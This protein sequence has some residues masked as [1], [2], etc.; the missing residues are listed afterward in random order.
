MESAYMNYYWIAVLISI[1]VICNIVLTI[2]RIL[3][4][5]ST[6]EVSGLI[7]TTG[8]AMA[9]SA[10]PCPKDIILAII[11]S[12]LDIH[13]NVGTDY[14]VMFCGLALIVLGIYYRRSI[15]DKIFVLNM[16]GIHT[17]IEISEESHLKE[18]HLPDFKVKENIID[19]VDLFQDGKMS[20]KKNDIIVKKINKKCNEFLNRSHDT[21]ACFT[22]MSPI[23]YTILAGNYLSNCGIKR[24][25]EYVSIKQ[26]FIELSH[27]KNKKRF[28]E[29][30]IRYPESIRAD[31]TELVL[32]L[33]ISRP[34]Q[35]LDLNQF[36]TD[37]VHIGLD[38]PQD[39]VIIMM[40]QL[41]Q[42]CDLV[43]KEIEN[44]RASY[45]SL[46]TIHLVASIPS[47]VSEKLG[48]LFRL[49]GNRLFKI[50]AYHFVNTN[51]PKYP[52]GITVC[53][54]NESGYGKFSEFKGKP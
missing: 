21:R 37:V 15:K 1:V 51:Q 32:A 29:L 48:E 13:I 26:T 42:Y 45:T 3:C 31:S 40:E 23:P 50:I 16:L 38:N 27:K 46:D 11:A 28:P 43:I 4:K 22:S 41:T 35:D 33:S 14:V 7:I 47:C 54:P 17:Q 5:E 10:I 39:N 34:V 36:N 52:F 44:L 25:F 9:I 2:K 53:S 6:T 20:S 12:F 49:R 19:F 24:Y 30:K 18:L 8:T